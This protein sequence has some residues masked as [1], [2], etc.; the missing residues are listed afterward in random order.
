MAACLCL[1]LIVSVFILLC[2][3][4]TFNDYF[5]FVNFIAASPSLSGR[6][7]IIM[8]KKKL[9]TI[10]SKFDYSNFWRERLCERDNL[11][12]ATNGTIYMSGLNVQCSTFCQYCRV[13]VY[14]DIHTIL[15]NLFTKTKMER[16]VAKISTIS[17]MY[18]CEQVWL[19]I[20]K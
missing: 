10:K 16:I 7:I 5:H 6:K 3:K 1:W 12:G 2:D 13:F 18:V 19:L 17:T 4:T 11:Y 8:K 15:I 20:L 9:C 14:I